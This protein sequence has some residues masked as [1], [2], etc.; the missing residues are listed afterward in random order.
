M[1]PR[2]FVLIA[3]LIF[4]SSGILQA[5]P[6][7]E[8]ALWIEI[9]KHGDSKTTIAMSEPIARQLLE[10]DD[11]E[12]RFT[13]EGDRDLITKKMLR[14]VLD[15]EE[16]SVEARSEDGTRVTLYMGELRVPGRSGNQQKLVFE[17]Y[18]SGSRTL[19]IALPEIE[20]EASNED[21]EGVG[22]IQGTI[23]WKG[24]LPFIAKEGGAVYLNTDDDETELWLYVE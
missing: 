21:D 4:I 19:R 8:R 2:R 7:R 17:T 9:K 13:K 22:N 6:P 24:L 18:K 1:G 16:E 5:F 10:S 11:R 12:V 14:D 23:G 15:G 3:G 20:I